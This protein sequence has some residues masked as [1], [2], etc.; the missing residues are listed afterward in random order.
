MRGLEFRAQGLLSS[1]QIQCAMQ[2]RCNQTHKEKKELEGVKR[3]G[4][5]MPR[6]NRFGVT[7]TMM[8]ARLLGVQH[9]MV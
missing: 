4:Q 1:D 5:H 3:G 6:A 2:P 8:L 9:W 7:R